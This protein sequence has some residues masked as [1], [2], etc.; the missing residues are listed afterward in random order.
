MVD[1]VA[2]VKKVIYEEKAYTIEDLRAAIDANF[3]G[4]EDLRTKLLAALNMEMMTIMSMILQQSYGHSLQTL[5]KALRITAVV[6][7]ILQCRW[8]RHILALVR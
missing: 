7:V 4:Y 5:P 3:E 6:I 2:A 1:S 8:Y